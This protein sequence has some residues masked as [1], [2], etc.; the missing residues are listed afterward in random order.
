MKRKANGKFSH[1]PM[2]SLF[3]TFP[4]EWND[5]SPVRH[6]G[7][8]FS[9]PAVT[10]HEQSESSSPIPL[11]RQRAQGEKWIWFISELVISSGVSAPWRGKSAILKLSIVRM[12]T[13]TAPS[14]RL[15]AKKLWKREKEGWERERKVYSGQ[16]DVSITISTKS[17]PDKINTIKK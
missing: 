12:V 7:M 14:Y 1:W 16:S 2:L 5:S 8:A 15:Q 3:R 4:Y 11:A 9:D 10:V 17:E 6:Y 13:S